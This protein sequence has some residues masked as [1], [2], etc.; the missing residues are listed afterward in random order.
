MKRLAEINLIRGDEAAAMK[1]LRILDKTLFYHRWARI[2]MPAERPKGL[3]RWMD[4]KSSLNVTTDTVRSPMDIETSFRHL[5]ESNPDNVFA[6]DYLLS[7]DL[8][9]KDVDTFV[10][11]YDLYLRG[12]AVT[13]R[14]WA[15]AMLIWLAAHGRSEE[16]VMARGIPPA[17]IEEF[18][19][20]NDIYQKA[21]SGSPTTFPTRQYQR[22]Q[23][24]FGKTY[25]FFYHFAQIN[26]N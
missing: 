15:E 6:R 10:Q 7:Y 5:L 1:Y 3:K 26:S 12:Q 21:V 25:W 13:Q 22:L 24:R 20:Y 2:H 23:E 17:V 19:E 4:M 8:L 18:M 9:D 16:E 11:D 14:T